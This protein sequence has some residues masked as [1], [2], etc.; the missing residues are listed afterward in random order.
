MLLFQQA[1]RGLRV[2]RNI[3]I[4]FVF[5]RRTQSVPCRLLVIDYQQRW[6]RHTFGKPGLPQARK[7]KQALRSITRQD[8]VLAQ[9]LPRSGLDDT[10]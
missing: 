9:L 3:D 6:W 8:A 5:Q 10:R 2:L 1:H 7:G 4:V